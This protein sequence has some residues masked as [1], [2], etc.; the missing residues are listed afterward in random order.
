MQGGGV[1]FGLNRNFK[2]RPSLRRGATCLDS[3]FADAPRRIGYLAAALRLGGERSIGS[4]SK[5]RS[6][7][8]A[9]DC[10]HSGILQYFC[11]I[12]IVG[13]KATVA[14]YL[15]YEDSIAGKPEFLNG[16]IFDMAGASLNHNRIVSNL[17]FELRRGLPGK[18]CE[19]FPGDM[20]VRLGLDTA[21]YY[22]DISVFCG[23]IDLV[24]DRDDIARNPIVVFEILSDATRRFNRGEKKHQ[25]MLLPSLKECIIVEQNRPL[26]DVYW[27][28]PKGKWEF[29]TYQ[30]LDETLKINSLGLE[31]PLREL[32]ALVAFE[33]EG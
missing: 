16:E 30:D 14:E 11:D 27:K 12:S 4:V 33:E 21:F 8:G 25:Y 5:T 20:K 9:R 3:L 15:A 2:G 31:I 32:Y 1:V 22:P 28:N 24:D 29:E 19:V 6:P 13:K 10:C 26:V 7:C 18:G 17:H 23:P